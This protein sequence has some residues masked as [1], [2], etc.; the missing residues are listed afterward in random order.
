MRVVW[1]RNLFYILFHAVS[2]YRNRISMVLHACTNGYLYK[3]HSH[4]CVQFYVRPG[5]VSTFLLLLLRDSFDVLFAVVCIPF[6]GLL[7]SN[8]SFGIHGYSNV[9]CG[10]DCMHSMDVLLFWGCHMLRNRAG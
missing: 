9:S 6:C 1:D 5:N 4:M 7:L 10:I 3:I 2:F 8:G